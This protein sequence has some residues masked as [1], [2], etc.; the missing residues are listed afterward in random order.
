M[1]GGL[2]AVVHAVFVDVYDPGRFADAHELPDL[3][4]DQLF[5]FRV[6]GRT[7]LG[8]HKTHAAQHARA[9]PLH[10]GEGA[11][12][13]GQA[14]FEILLPARVLGPIG[15]RTAETVD[16]DAARVKMAAGPLESLLG[17]I[18]YVDPVDAAG[19]DVSAMS[20]TTCEQPIG[21]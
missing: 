3:P 15:H 10:P 2:P 12:E 5:D 11:P 18:R 14:V 8:Q 19:L 16:A 4:L 1:G 6:V 7:V 9:R 17:D 20:R 13:L 21:W